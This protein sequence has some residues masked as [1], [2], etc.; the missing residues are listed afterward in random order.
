[1]IKKNDLPF[2]NGK[3]LMKTCGFFMIFIYQTDEFG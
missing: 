3:T 2:R 1:M